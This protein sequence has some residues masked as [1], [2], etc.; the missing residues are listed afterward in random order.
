MPFMT[1]IDS[2]GVESSINDFQLFL[3]EKLF[4]ILS[5]N[6]EH[7]AA[8]MGSRASLILSSRFQAQIIIRKINANIALKRN[9][10]FHR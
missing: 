8:S 2:R 1:F 10:L 6:E 7:C 5:Q 4:S 9:Y 3:S